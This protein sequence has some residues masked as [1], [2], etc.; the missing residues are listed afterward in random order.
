MKI[1]AHAV[2]RAL[3]VRS[4]IGRQLIGRFFDVK[5]WNALSLG[6]LRRHLRVHTTAEPAKSKADAVEYTIGIRVTPPHTSPTLG[7]LTSKEKPRP[8]P[9][10]PIGSLLGML[11]GEAWSMALCARVSRVWQLGV[12]F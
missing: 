9:V 11:E 6:L 10:A 2:M 12:V 3:V 8:Q 1:H 4:L 5:S 7:G